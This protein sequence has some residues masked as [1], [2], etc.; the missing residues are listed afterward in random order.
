MSNEVLTKSCLTSISMVNS[1]KYLF[2]MLHQC[3]STL[4]GTELNRYHAQIV[5]GAWMGLISILTSFSSWTSLNSMEMKVTAAQLW[6]IQRLTLL[7]ILSF[8]QRKSVRALALQ[9]LEIFT[10]FLLTS[11]VLNK[12]G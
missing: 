4:D 1:F 7:G 10:P 11:Y 5:F 8:N 2:R 6:A 12:F 3:L 9:T